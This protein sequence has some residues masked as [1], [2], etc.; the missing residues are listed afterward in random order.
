MCF[1]LA[2]SLTWL[3]LTVELQNWCTYY[4]VHH[5]YLLYFSHPPCPSQKV[6]EREAAQGHRVTVTV[7][8]HWF[9]RKWSAPLILLLPNAIRATPQRRKVE[10]VQRGY[11]NHFVCSTLWFFMVHVPCGEVP[12]TG[13]PFS[14]DGGPRA[15]TVSSFK[16]GL[17]QRFTW[18][19]GRSSSLPISAF[20]FIQLHFPP[21]YLALPWYNFCGWLG[22]TS[23]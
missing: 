23:R 8:P 3:P 15:I 7:E 4:T 13:S 17:C 5:T 20:W 10:G 19:G 22:F 9:L 6:T 2:A 12:R 16:H 21:E 1:T 14:W 11:L 18:A